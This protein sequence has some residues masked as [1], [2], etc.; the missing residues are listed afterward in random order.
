MREEQKIVRQW[1]QA[2][3]TQQSE[4]QRL[5]LRAT[6]RGERAGRLGQ[7]AVVEDEE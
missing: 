6:Q 3:Q 5:V 4:L 1:A 2:Q 7:R